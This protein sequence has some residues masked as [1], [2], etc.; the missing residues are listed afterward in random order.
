MDLDVY[1]VASAPAAIPR[2]RSRWPARLDV[3]QALSGLLLV[4][5]IWFHMLLESSIF[6]G[7][8]AMYRVARFMD[9]RYLLGADYPFLVTCAA[10]VILAI[11]AVHAALVMRKFPASH[12]E[13]RA[14]RTQM[15][16][17]R[18]P[19][20]TLWWLQV[21]TGF[22]LFF[23]GSAHIIGVMTRSGDIG[24]YESADRI[25]N[26]W[27]WPVYALLLVTVHLHAGVGV[28]R[29][30]VKWGLQLWRDPGT[31]LRRLKLARTI[32]IAFFILLGSASLAVYVA[33]GV[34]HRDHKGER[35]RPPWEHSA[36][37]TQEGRAETAIAPAAPH[38]VAP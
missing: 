29:L 26:D 23:L 32:I 19:D 35:Y 20:T 18:H 6:L 4:L 15:A 37:T 33:I 3:M 13:Y 22:A 31:N 11:F 34:G 28:Y 36:T 12:R 21:W 16:N 30:A 14:F 10:G 25:V 38:G 24:P 5:F 2:D 8:D 17:F 9:G 7:K 1:N 27:M